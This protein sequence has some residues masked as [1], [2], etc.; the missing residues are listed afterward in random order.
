MKSIKTT[1]PLSE[2]KPPKNNQDFKNYLQQNDRLTIIDKKM[3]IPL[4]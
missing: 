4:E 3:T 1:A 2:N